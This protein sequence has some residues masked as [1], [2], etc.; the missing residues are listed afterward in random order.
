MYAKVSKKGQVTI[1]K[2]IR[3][4]LNIGQDS[5][6]LFVIENGEVKLK[7]VPSGSPEELA[8]SLREYAETYEPLDEIRLKIQ[9]DLA[10]EINKEHDNGS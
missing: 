1:P 3:K 4:K 5:A 9:E 7:D 6:V 10:K 8:G 2:A